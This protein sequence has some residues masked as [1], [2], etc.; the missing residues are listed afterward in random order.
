MESI[1]F[2]ILNLKEFHQLEEEIEQISSK[3]RGS[4]K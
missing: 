2:R 3:K 4:G 1:I